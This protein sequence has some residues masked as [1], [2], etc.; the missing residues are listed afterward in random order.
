MLGRSWPCGGSPQRARRASAPL[1]RHFSALPAGPARAAV[2]CVR[3][4]L[5]ARGA[6]IVVENFAAGIMEKLGLG[7]AVR[8]ALNPGLIAISMPAFGNDGPLSGIRAYGSTVEQACGLP[9]ANG[10]D[11]WPPCL[12]HVAFG[13]PLAGLFGDDAAP[14][15]GLVDPLVNQFIPYLREIW[16]AKVLTNG[17]PFHQRLEAA[18]VEHLGLRHLSLFTNGTLGLL[19]ALQTLQVTGEVITTPYSFAATAHSVHFGLR[20]V[21]T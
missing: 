12:Q 4:Y 13:D 8:R 14:A 20:A 3:D 15:R 1:Y 18:L 17:G 19:T 2:G 7:P 11:H 6:D 21:H 9:F 5:L 10:H 16:D